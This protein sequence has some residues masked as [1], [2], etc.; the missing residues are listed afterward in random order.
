M[1]KLDWFN[2]GHEAKTPPGWK[3]GWKNGARN[4]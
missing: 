3:S 2:D 4:S 1:L